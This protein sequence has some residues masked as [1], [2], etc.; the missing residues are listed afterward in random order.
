MNWALSLLRLCLI[1]PSGKSKVIDRVGLAIWTGIAMAPV[2][3][4][5]I[6]DKDKLYQGLTRPKIFSFFAMLSIHGNGVLRALFTFPAFHHLVTNAPEALRPPGNMPAKAL[7][8]GTVMIFSG[9]S[10]TASIYGKASVDER[11]PDIAFVI[12]II[13]GNF[14]M[15]LSTFLIGVTMAWLKTGF[16]QDISVLGHARRKL[17]E[18][19]CLKAAIA[20]LLFIMYAVRVLMLIVYPVMIFTGR[21]TDSLCMM[22]LVVA[23]ASVDIFYINLVTVDAYDYIKSLIYILR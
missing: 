1:I 13:F 22:L 14:L 5:I 19:I 10:A 18:F 3:L 15:A 11:S 2:I 23:Y 17:E 12:M 8:F 6:S 7:L 20:P 4:V 9:L 21:D 16:Q